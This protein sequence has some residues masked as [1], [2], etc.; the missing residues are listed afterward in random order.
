MFDP[1]C[2]VG[3]GAVTCDFG[4]VQILLTGEVAKWYVEATTLLS[5]V[6]PHLT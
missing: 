1:V 3:Q 6:V 5:E 2:A 4:Q